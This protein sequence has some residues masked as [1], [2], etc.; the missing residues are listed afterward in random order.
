M[1]SAVILRMDKYI[2]MI[3]RVH[4]GKTYDLFPGGT[5]QVGETVEV[6]AIR[7]V[8][9]EL[10]LVIWV[11]QLAA[12]VE[13][14]GQAQSYFW[15]THVAGEFGTGDGE[16]LNSSADSPRGSYGPVWIHL[17]HFPLLDIRPRALATALREGKFSPLSEAL[18]LQEEERSA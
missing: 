5:V 14:N 3:E 18:R 13:F 11:G 1:R 7:E 6:T 15:A 4:A 12:D 10:G 2:A 9:E 8:R 17:D 16:E